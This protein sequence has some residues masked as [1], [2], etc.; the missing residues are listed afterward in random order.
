MPRSRATIV[1][2]LQVGFQEMSTVQIMLHEIVAQRLSLNAIEHKV[3]GLLS[4]RGR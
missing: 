4:R 3:M 2:A 1:E